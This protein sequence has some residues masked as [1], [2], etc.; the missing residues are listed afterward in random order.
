MGPG[1]REL[2]KIENLLNPN[3]VPFRLTYRHSVMMKPHS[4]AIDWERNPVW[5][6]VM[7]APSVFANGFTM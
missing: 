4:L 6:G 2:G 5:K 3:L 7:A 1:L